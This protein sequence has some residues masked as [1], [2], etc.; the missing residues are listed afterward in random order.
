MRVQHTDVKPFEV[1]KSYISNV[2]SSIFNIFSY[3]KQ[4]GV[5]GKSFKLKNTLRN[6]QVQHTGIKKYTCTWCNRSFASSGN[7]YSHRKRMHPKEL[8]A[9][10]LKQEEEDR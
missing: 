3:N 2:Y 10:K 7:Y 1:K 9:L 8:A 4:C 5:C 6:H